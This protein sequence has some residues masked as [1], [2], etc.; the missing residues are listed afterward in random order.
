MKL[1]LVWRQNYQAVNPSLFL[2]ALTMMMVMMAA[3][4]AFVSAT[5]GAG[6]GAVG[7]GVGGCWS[8]CWLSSTVTSMLAA[9][10]L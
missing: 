5:A 3:A 4:T 6:A 7:V 1:L 9:A 10:A 8:C 2:S